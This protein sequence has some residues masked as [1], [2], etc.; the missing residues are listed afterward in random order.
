[1]TTSSSSDDSSGTLNP[2]TESLDPGP[3]SVTYT[4]IASAAGPWRSEQ[5]VVIA[6]PDPSVDALQIPLPFFEN[7]GDNTWQFAVFLLEQIVAGKG[8]IIE[9]ST[10]SQVVLSH[11][12]APGKYTYRPKDDNS[13]FAW[14]R[15]PE[16]ANRYRAPRDE[17]G[18]DGS[19]GISAE[20]DT[21]VSICRRLTRFR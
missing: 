6:I 10:G 3:Y 18:W 5:K 8:C 9:D 1:M 16:G 12:P 14:V 15:G 21:A 13:T 17:E 7:S 19:S 2:V 11:S 4:N 20:D